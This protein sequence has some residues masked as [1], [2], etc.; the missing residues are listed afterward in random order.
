MS[1]LRDFLVG[2][3][4]EN[5]RV[6]LD[7]EHGVV[8]INGKR[9]SD[10]REVFDFLRNIPSSRWDDGPEVDVVEITTDEAL[11]YLDDPG[12]HNARAALQNL[13]PGPSED[14]HITA[15]MNEAQMPTGEIEIGRRIR[16]DTIRWDDLES[17]I[18]SSAWTL[19]NDGNWH[20]HLSR[21]ELWQYID[22]LPPRWPVE[23][24]DDDWV[25]PVDELGAEYPIGRRGL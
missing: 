18:P 15:L 7:H 1:K 4:A 11:A 13:F 16:T 19:G 12:L 10:T 6:F 14:F 8:R 5:L 20:A 9:Y 2:L 21:A 3:N 22:A 24:D 23:H 25:N 17:V